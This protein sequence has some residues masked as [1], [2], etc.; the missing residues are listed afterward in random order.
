MYENYG[1]AQFR[2]ID[3]NWPSFGKEENK[4]VSW[5]ISIQSLIR[6]CFNILIRLCSPSRIRNIK[7]ERLEELYHN[8]TLHLFSHLPKLGQ[9]CDVSWTNERISCFCS[10]EDSLDPVVLRVSGGAGQ[11]IQSPALERIVQIRRVFRGGSSREGVPTGSPYPYTLRIA[12]SFKGLIL[13]VKY[14]ILAES[15]WT[16]EKLK[17][18]SCECECVERNSFNFL[19]ASSPDWTPTGDCLYTLV[20][21]RDSQFWTVT[22]G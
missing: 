12:R 16:V 10:Q 7:L 21:P 20:Y 2:S 14:E 4:R 9:W 19:A 6:Q 11:C 15:F 8:N 5:L 3:V 18:F 22:I 1:F 13:T 17:L